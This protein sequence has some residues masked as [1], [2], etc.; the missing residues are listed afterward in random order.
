MY[1]N[2]RNFRVLQEIWV[3]EY[4]GDVRCLT[5][6]GNTAVSRIRNASGH[7][8]RNSSVIV[9]LAMGQI[10][11]STERITSMHYFQNMPSAPVSRC[12]GFLSPNTIICPP[13]KNMLRAPWTTN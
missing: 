3:E 2:C 13:L 4:D 1:A 11:R 6:S 9:D 12:G 5:G 8:Y 10:R 7:N